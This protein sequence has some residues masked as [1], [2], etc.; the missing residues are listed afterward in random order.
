MNFS[1]FKQKNQIKEK[2]ILASFVVLKKK[3]VLFLI[4]YKFNKILNF[5]LR[6]SKNDFPTGPVVIIYNHVI[7]FK[8]LKPQFLKHF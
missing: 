2:I 8:C 7:S 3:T 1:P 6:K 4:I 5:F